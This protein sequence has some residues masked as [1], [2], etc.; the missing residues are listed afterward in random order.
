[1]PELK[2]NSGTLIAGIA[3]GWLGSVLLR[4][5]GSP[6]NAED[7]IRS[8]VPGAG[9]Q[10]NAQPGDAMRELPQVVAERVRELMLQGFKIGIDR[11]AGRARA[12]IL[13]PEGQP[14]APVT[15]ARGAGD[16]IDAEF[17]EL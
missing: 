7:V 15:G 13:G 5:M 14:I 10:P 2:D 4:K 11:A 1:M 16:V 17:V 8:V 6:I 3:I 12:W 9:A